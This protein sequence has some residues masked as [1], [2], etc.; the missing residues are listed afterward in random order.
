[1]VLIVVPKGLKL[2]VVVLIRRHIVTPLPKR[3]AAR[4]IV[5]NALAEASK[6]NKARVASPLRNN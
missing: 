6:L 4:T 5:K 2:Q 3:A 1:V